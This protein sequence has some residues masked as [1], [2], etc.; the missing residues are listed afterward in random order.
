[1]KRPWF[2]LRRFARD[3]RGVSA[4]EFAFIAPVLIIF[5]F[6]MAQTTEAMM[7][8]RRV[9]HV[10][11]IIGDLIAQ[12]ESV[13]PAEFTDL[14]KVGNTLMS[15]FP[16]TGK[17]GMR[18]TSV[19]ANAAGAAKIDWSCVGGTGLT[20]K[21]KTNTWTGIP[22][23]LIAPG[24]SLVIAETLYPY[25]SPVKKYLPKTLNFGGIYYLRPRK[26]TTVQLST[27]CS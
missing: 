3:Q 13:T 17:L 14:W 26:I 4:I 22:A 12:D 21:T 5:Y 25:D 7:A 11:S 8:K 6:G 19:T 15:P 2:S 9:G 18:I 23:G 10:A 20:A 16:T 24:Q 1:M 27:T